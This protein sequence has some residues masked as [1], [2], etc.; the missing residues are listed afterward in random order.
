MSIALPA[1]PGAEQNP[2]TGRGGA[3]VLLGPQEGEPVEHVAVPGPVRV[4]PH[5]HHPEQPGAF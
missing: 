1:P 2:D 4:A 3:V 5:A